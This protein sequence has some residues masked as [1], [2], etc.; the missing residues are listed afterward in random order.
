MRPELT[1]PP[2]SSAGDGAIVLSGVSKSFGDHAVFRDFSVRIR[3][4]GVTAV[5]GPSGCGKT[6]LTAMLLGLE[7]PDRG[8]V[9]NPHTEISCAFQDPRLLPWKTATENV[10]LVLRRMPR[11][12]KRRIAAEILTSLGLGDALGKRPSE[13]SGGMQQR[14]S[15]AR[16][17]AMPHTLL[18][19][20]E[21]FRGLDEENRRTV[22]ARIR[23]L[24]ETRPVLLVTHDP[25]DAEALDAEVIRLSP[26]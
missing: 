12:E 20:D 24:A 17:F 21:P 26:L 25:A 4:R 13:L 8:T 22:T 23:A 9:E 19:L 15:L 18:I 6:T 5:M 11:R 16:A 3:G 2:L 7:T 14:V 1:N 10:A